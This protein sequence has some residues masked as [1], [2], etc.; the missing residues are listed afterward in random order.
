MFLGKEAAQTQPSLTQSVCLFCLRCFRLYETRG[1]NM[2]G[3]RNSQR[4]VSLPNSHADI[5][6]HLLIIS[7]GFHPK[8]Q[9]IVPLLLKKVFC[10]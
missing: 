9:N 10:V 4:V 8:F 3:P 2:L 7:R 1:A 5:V 6:Q